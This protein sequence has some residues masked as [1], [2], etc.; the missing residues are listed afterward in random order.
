MFNLRK[1]IEALKKL[2]PRRIYV[3]NVRSY[4]GTTTE[5]AKLVCEM[6]VWKGL[7][8]KRYGV[9]CPNSDECGR[10]IASYESISDIPET[11]TCEICESN[12]REFEWSKSD[13]KVMVFYNYLR[14]V[15]GGEAKKAIQVH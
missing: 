14:P 8:E 3:E 7:F 13:L 12:D 11:I 6:A 15:N 5:V 1:S 10:I 2:N 9:L 4:L